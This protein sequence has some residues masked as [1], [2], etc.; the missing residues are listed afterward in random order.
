MDF[1]EAQDKAR[2]NTWKLIVLYILAVALLIAAV[3]VV[4]TLVFQ[5][6]EPAVP[7]S[8][9][10]WNPQLLLTVS[11]VVLMIILAGTAYRVSQ[12][13]RG[14]ASVAE[15]MGGRQVNPS[16]RDSQERQLMNVV[17]EI[18]I[19]SGIPVPDVYVLDNEPSIN[20]FAAGF[21]TRDAAVGVTRGTLQQ[22][23]RDELQG[24]IA[25]EFSHIFHGDM[26]LNI[27]L[28]GILNGILL[29]HIIG[30]ILM[31]G[32]AFSSI[33]RSSGGRG[34]GGAMAI[35]VVGLALLI[36]GYI[37]MLFGRII[38]SA[39][40][41]QREY[42]AD[43][44]AVQYTRNPEGLAGALHKIKQ[45]KH[46]SDIRD[47]HA[48]EFSHLFFASSFRSALDRL[49]ATHPPVDERIE[50]ID[51]NFDPKST[52]RQK[53]QRK[54][55]R[56]RQQQ[57]QQRIASPFEGNEA[58][59]DLATRM[60]EGMAGMARP[61]VLI[62]A[63][64]TLE[65]GQLR[66]AGHLLNQLPAELRQA[67]HDP[68]EG[69]ALVYALLLID[70][71]PKARE[72]PVWLHENVDETMRSH[73][74]RLLP[75]LASVNRESQL[76]LID[77]SI[78]VL[79]QLSDKQYVAF[80]QNAEHLISDPE[81]QREASLFGF[82]LEKILIR[83]LDTAFREKKTEKVAYHR[84]KD[85]QQDVSVLLSALAHASQHDP[86][87]SWQQAQN[88]LEQVAPDL[89]FMQPQECGLKRV[90]E[91]LDR[92]A[93]SAN[94]VKKYFLTAA[95]RGVGADGQVSQDEMEL[96]RAIAEAID[97]PMPMQRS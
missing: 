57:E 60:A 86:G 56:R 14:G 3:Y 44:A 52:R 96:L 29:L 85:L 77:L 31:R 15:M 16:T 93:R 10:L 7:L 50:A 39:V 36:I 24:V 63:I 91:A 87:E 33:G 66:R 65:A 88:T 83:H 84:I 73:I 95:I 47:G 82:A 43:A 20:A 40:S 27:R 49:F 41:R 37:G 78:P 72:L 42:L 53:R 22:L 48:M 34:G 12:L 38:Q 30:L 68:V 89:Q 11:A 67:A 74:H 46:G 79:R 69:Q 61:E 2:R 25:H 18:S 1:F 26:R 8:Q 21:G 4:V 17:E 55:Q 80:R 9:R 76:L 90:D 81:E 59:G 19:A 28:I 58:E 13:R 97:C 45:K 92:L 75:L 23:T 94:P 71:D 64:G 6:E 35:L 51:P 54:Q 62:A 32:G 5:P 70:R